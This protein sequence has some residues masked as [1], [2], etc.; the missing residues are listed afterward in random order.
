VRISATAALALLSAQPVL[1]ACPIELATYR[2]RDG[3]ADL[4][5]IPVAGSAA[6][7]NKFHVAMKGGPVFEGVVM[8]TEGPARSNGLLMFNCPEGDVTGAELDACTIWQGVI[9]GIDDKGEVGLLPAEGQAAPQKLILA[10]LAGWMSSAPAFTN[11]GLS[12]VPWDG[13]TLSGCQE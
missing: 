13:F 10:D 5:F 1:A 11:A 2:D 4:E 6:V 7:T 9:Y 8:W 3:I 12:T